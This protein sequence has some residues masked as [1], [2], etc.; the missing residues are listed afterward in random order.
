VKVSRL[1]L[2]EFRHSPATE[3]LNPVKSAASRTGRCSSV[4]VVIV[5]AVTVA[6]INIVSVIQLTM[7]S[8][9]LPIQPVIL[10]IVTPFKLPVHTPVAAARHI[11]IVVVR[12]VMLGIES[13]MHTIVAVFQNPVTLT[14]LPIESAMF[15]LM[16]IIVGCSRSC[17]TKRKDSSNKQFGLQ[18]AHQ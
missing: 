5:I 7:Q 17:E 18:I 2:N 13:A 16:V 9:V 3:V 4:W 12:R 1:L 6:V 15:S 14:M 11:G 10:P 8:V